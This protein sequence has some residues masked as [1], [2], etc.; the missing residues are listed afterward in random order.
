[1]IND[2]FLVFYWW[3]LTFI[4]SLM[5]FPLID[6]LLGKFWDRGYPF[7]KP[8][9]V[10][11]VSYLCWVLGSLQLL[12][13]TRQITWL[14]V[15]LLGFLIWKNKKLKNFPW[16]KLIKEKGQVFFFEEVLFFISLLFWSYIRGFQPDI[17]G[18]EKY[19]DYGFV[20]SILKARS[21]PPLDMW[22]S[23]ET[24]NY[25]YFGHSV[26]AVLTKLSGLDSSV[27]YNLML[28]TLFALCLSIT[29]SLAS[30][31]LFFSL[32][33]KKLSKRYFRLIISAGL[34]SALLL[35][36][37]G[38]LQHLWYFLKN[39]TFSGYWY[40]DATRFIIQ[41]FG[42]LDNTIHEFPIYSFVVADLHGHLL[43]LPFV[44]LFLGLVLGISRN[45]SRLTFPNLILPALILA[46]MSMTNFWDFPI[47]SLVLGLIILWLNYRKH[48]RTS[49]TIYQTGLFSVFF[50]TLSVVFSLPF[51][52]DFQSI[53]QGISRVD[54]RSPPWMLFFLWGLPLLMT[55]NFFILS[56]WLVRSKKQA[57]SDFF[58]L[59]LLFVS[60]LLILIPEIVYVKD[61]YIH[62]YQRANTMF[63]LTYQSFVMFSLCSGYIVVRTLT[64]IKKSWIKIPLIIGYWSLIIF[65]LSYP[66]FAIKSYY[67]LKKYQGLDGLKYFQ[68]FYPDDYQA[69]LWLKRKII[70]QPVIL[71]AVGESYTDY[72]RVSANTGLAT[73]VGW[74]VHEWLWR[75]GYDEVGVRRED[76]RMIYESESLEQTENLLR[77][78][79]VDFVFIGDLERK[80]YQALNED[81]FEEF[82]KVVFQ[83]GKTTIYQLND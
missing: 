28:A 44:L 68:S 47:Y 82:G 81:K 40:P 5:V 14:V 62:S 11:L 21:F 30:N 4:L 38:N 52:L 73:V 34:L 45:K 18:L 78:Y 20:N 48:G 76:V 56:R 17:H 3:G 41:K 59:V 51:H 49:K 71:E 29:F 32:N 50:F 58:V 65:L 46:V 6:R 60:W 70:G 1:M 66:Y 54:F 13:L 12:S 7:A 2:F 25:Y 53:A 42:A 61:I 37:G 24:I 35:N 69:V 64:S 33:R 63:K 19:M 27:T 77:K 55:V 83:Q 31:L 74:P 8:L 43:D 67:G 16:E 23:G 75:G 15:I 39:K 79:E 9:S 57:L 80:Q 26:A 22:M 36:L 10:L 72:A